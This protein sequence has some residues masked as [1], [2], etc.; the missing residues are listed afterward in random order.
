[1]KKRYHNVLV[2]IIKDY[3]FFLGYKH[4]KGGKA[5]SLLLNVYEALT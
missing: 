4:K 3:F 1:M 5:I 2:D